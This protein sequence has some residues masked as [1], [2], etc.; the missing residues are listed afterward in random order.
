MCINNYP[1]IS[2]KTLNPGNKDYVNVF[3]ENIILYG[4][5]FTYRFKPSIKE[6]ELALTYH[7]IDNEVIEKE[8]YIYMGH[9]G[10]YSS[11]YFDALNYLINSSYHSLLAVKM[12]KVVSPMIEALEPFRSYAHYS[13]KKMLPVID[14]RLYRDKI[15]GDDRR[16]VDLGLPEIRSNDF[17]E[18]FVER[19]VPLII[20][21]LAS[22]VHRLGQAL[23]QIA[24]QSL[25]YAFYMIE[26]YSRSGH[27]SKDLRKKYIDIISKLFS[28][29]VFDTYIWFPLAWL[30]KI[31]AYG[32]EHIYAV[33]SQPVVQML[34]I[35]DPSRFSLY[36]CL[37]D[38]IRSAIYKELISSS[39]KDI[40][41]LVNRLSE[42]IMREISSYFNLKNLNRETLLGSLIRYKNVKSDVPKNIVLTATEQFNPLHLLVAV[43]RFTDSKDLSG[44]N[45][46]II[47]YTPQTLYNVLLFKELLLGGD[48]D[49]IKYILIPSTEP[50]IVE[51]IS[52]R[53][54]NNLKPEDT[55]LILQGG[56]VY[57]MPIY[58]KAREKGFH[59]I[60]VI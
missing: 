41:G 52:D 48:E 11:I 20:I 15:I 16:R 22:G 2:V 21:S 45:K 40:F 58:M 47:L 19:V 51:S 35:L 43:E 30:K 34:D 14:N 44:F 39:N 12:Y 57:V 13:L 18:F 5:M 6:V 55:L 23:R 7:V 31:G 38:R 33:A 17:T 1:L 4:S 3:L 9:G 53:L 54:L 25:V 28:A 27:I 49:K 29:I 42:I 24:S 59:N 60:I 32:V 37:Y 36:L 56:L 46:I 50:Y 10:K 8:L 26:K